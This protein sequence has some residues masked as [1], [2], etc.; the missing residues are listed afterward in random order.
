VIPEK[1]I[2]NLEDWLK[3]FDIEGS[4]IKD[5]DGDAVSVADMLSIITERDGR[6]WD[7]FACYSHKNEA[8]F[9]ARNYSERGPNGLMRH[10]LNDR[11]IAQGDGTWD[12]I[13]G[14]FS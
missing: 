10:Q 12:C 7:R 13:V 9:H 6:H 8:D 4:H 1:G 2:N 11:C 3:K 14:E 5:E